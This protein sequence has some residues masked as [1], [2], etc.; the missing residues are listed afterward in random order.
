MELPFELFLPELRFAVV[1]KMDRIDRKIGE[2]S[3]TKVARA[4][5]QEHIM[6]TVV[7]TILGAI[8]EVVICICKD[9]YVSVETMARSQVVSESP[10]SLTRYMRVRTLDM[11]A[12]S[13]VRTGVCGRGGEPLLTERRS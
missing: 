1:P 10:I 6:P 13:W 9:T 5:M 4:G 8:S 12:L 3:R 2:W 11:Q 7:S